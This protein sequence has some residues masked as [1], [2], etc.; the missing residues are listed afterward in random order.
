MAALILH[1]C[2]PD[3]GRKLLKRKSQLGLLL[4][5]LLHFDKLAASLDDTRL[6]QRGN[7]L[8]DRD[9]DRVSEL[10]IGLSV[11]DRNDKAAFSRRIE[12]HQPSAFLRGEAT[13][14]IAH[15]FR[16]I[17][18]FSVIEAAVDE[19]LRAVLVIAG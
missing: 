19:N 15:V 12:A 7:S 18:W 8:E 3:R 16:R 11:R 13:W 17:E 1:K 5:C 6:H 4:G 14:P 9:N 10:A 2:I